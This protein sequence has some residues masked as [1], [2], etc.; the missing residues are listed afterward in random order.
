MGESFEGVHLTQCC[1]LGL[2]VKRVEGCCAAHVEPIP[3]GAAEAD[4]G[5]ALRCINLADHFPVRRVDG[6]AII[7]F[8]AAHANPEIAVPITAHSVRCQRPA[9]GED[10]G[11]RQLRSVGRHIIDTNLARAGPGLDDVELGFVRGEAETVRPLDVVRHH[12]DLL[13]LRIPA[14]D[15]PRQEWRGLV[16]LVV[17]TDAEG[18]IGKPD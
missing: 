11:V 9:G 6:H 16:S 2:G 8:P 10:A 13:R 1:A 5:H 7:P 15:V 12:G 4:I 3:F 18:G 17:S 14:V